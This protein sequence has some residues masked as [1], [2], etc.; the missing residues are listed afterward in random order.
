MCKNVKIIN[1][2]FTD[3]LLVLGSNSQSRLAYQLSDP[4]H[5]S[6]C[7]WT[8]N[9]QTPSSTQHQFLFFYLTSVSVRLTPRLTLHLTLHLTPYHQNLPSIKS[10][11]PLKVVYHQKLSSSKG[12]LLSKVVFHQRS[13]SVKDRLPSKVVFRH[14]SSSVKGRLPSKVVFRQRS[15]SVI[16]RLL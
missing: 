7:V 2:S 11:L 1:K 4:D 16:G 5:F 13:S 6:K 3:N 8:Q 9:C 15:S 14:R 12:C 10:R